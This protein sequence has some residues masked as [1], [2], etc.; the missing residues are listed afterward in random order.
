MRENVM[1]GHRMNRKPDDTRR[2]RLSLAQVPQRAPA[3]LT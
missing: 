1:T 3:Y 2:R